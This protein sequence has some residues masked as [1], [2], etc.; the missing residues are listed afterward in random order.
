MPKTA[1]SNFIKRAH[2]KKSVY[3]E[4]SVPSMVY[5]G[6]SGGKDLQF[7]WSCIT[8]PFVMENQSAV[9]KVD[10]FLFF[11]GHNAFDYRDFQAEIELTLGEK[12]E[13]FT[14]K[15]PKLVYIPKGLRCGPIN[16]KKVNKAVQLMD[17]HLSPKYSK[18][19]TE[20]DY[21]KYFGTPHYMDMNLDFKS[22]Q[23]GQLAR[24]QIVKY[25]TMIGLGKMAGGGNLSAFWHTMD[26]AH[27]MQ[28]PV[29]THDFDMW[30]VF[31]PAN[32]LNVEDW[33][34]KI[35]MFWGEDSEEQDITTPAVVHIPAGLI[36]RSVDY[37]RIKKPFYHINL[38][39]APEY[40]K[41]KEKIISK[42]G[43]I[44]MPDGVKG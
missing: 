14:V 29:H 44:Q 21:S 18:A 9:N 12:G 33:D 8:K 36:H 28:E 16:F 7:D 10:R 23:N 6:D 13:K 20:K 3:P 1:Y 2:Y 4:I 32:P 17:F 5:R 35:E 15:D 43:D 19:G 31:L 38:F 41:E 42:L 25:P 22:Y 37:R 26:T 30:A 24:E 11:V 39:N 40:F 34:A 27:V